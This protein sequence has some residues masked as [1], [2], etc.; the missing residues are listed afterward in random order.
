MVKVNEPRYDKN[1]KM[2]V[3][4]AKTQSDQSS[5]CSQWVAKDPRFL[6]ADSEDSDQTGR[7]PWLIWVFPGRTLT[8][9]VLSCRRSNVSNCNVDSQRKIPLGMDGTVYF[10]PRPRVCLFLPSTQFKLLE[11]LPNDEIIQ[12]W[13]P[14]RNSV[15]ASNRTLTSK[16]NSLQPD[17]LISSHNSS[18]FLLV[19]DHYPCLGSGHRSN[20][21]ILTPLQ[22][23][24]LCW[25]FTA[26]S[27]TRS[28]RAGHYSYKQWL[29]CQ[30]NVPTGKWNGIRKPQTP[31]YLNSPCPPAPLAKY[32]VCKFK[33]ISTEK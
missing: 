21:L 30:A 29:A 14:V 26:Q 31:E 16:S 1:N 2:S 3:R 9:L 10:Q 23:L 11:I 13:M 32:F 20:N 5:L 17:H 19:C 6:Q 8:L 12:N 33:I 4:P 28:C 27:T 22:L 18:P 25:G 7:M 24:C 15:A